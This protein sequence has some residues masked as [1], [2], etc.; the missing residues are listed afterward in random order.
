MNSENSTQNSIDHSANAGKPEARPLGAVVERIIASLCP[1]PEIEE[2]ALADAAGRVLARELQAPTPLPA[3]DCAAM[4]GFALR[5]SDLPGNRPAEFVVAGTALAGHPWCEPCPRGAAVRIMTGAPMPDGLDTVVPQELVQ[6]TASGIRIEPAAQQPGRH[7][8]RAGEDLARGSPVLAAGRRLDATDLGLAASL[9]FARLPVRRQLRV[10]LLSTGSELRALGTP[11]G[12]GQIYDSNR[13]M[14]SA[15]L[16]RLGVRVVDLGLVADQPAALEASMRKA[17]RCADAIISTGGVS[18]GDADHT[19]SIMGRLG[20]VDFWRV[21]L[22]PGR[23]LAYGHIGGTPYFGLPGNPFA[24]L[25]SFL[26]VARPA[27]LAL[28]GA[29]PSPPLG[30]PARVRHALAKRPGRTEL[31]RARLVSATDAVLEV[32]PTRA[33]GSATLGL[34]AQSDCFIFLPHERGP[35]ACG[36]T[37]ECLPFAGLL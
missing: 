14:L 34:M 27:L 12:F 13:Y 15:L 33:Q 25:A 24:A 6:P 29:R 32:E 21:A 4:D 18:V 5:A 28:C 20:R 22:R 26:L 7:R 8:R 2:A 30:V 10:A 3:W 31:H 17:A 37:V 36:E 19:R 23:P 16:A 35:V 9:G 1:V 11:L